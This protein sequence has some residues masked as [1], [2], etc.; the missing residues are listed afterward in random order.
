MLH[1]SLLTVLPT[2]KT[3]LPTIFLLKY[4]HTSKSRPATHYTV[5]CKD[6]LPCFHHK[7]CFRAIFRDPIQVAKFVRI[8][9]TIHVTTKESNMSLFEPLSP[10]MIDDFGGHFFQLC[11]RNVQ[12]YVL[13]LSSIITAFIHSEKTIVAALCQL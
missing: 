12:K 9:L 10:I 13:V 8:R 6:S 2:D 7:R 1:T 4:K 3:I 11:P 5:V